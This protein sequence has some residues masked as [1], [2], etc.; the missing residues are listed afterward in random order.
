MATRGMRTSKYSKYARAAYVCAALCFS[1]AAVAGVVA[2]AAA[3]TNPVVSV[4]V[5]DFA[6]TP[7]TLTIVKGTQVRFTNTG[8]S[9]HRVVSDDGTFD[10]HPLQPGHNATFTFDTVGVFHLHCEIHPTMTMSVTVLASQ[11]VAAGAGSGSSS[12]TSESA[13]AATTVTSATTLP[14]TGTGLMTA[15]IA[16]FGL[17]LILLGMVCLAVGRTRFA[18]IPAVAARP[19]MASLARVM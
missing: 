13:T 9:L 14:R 15:L 11:P 2:A 19:A 1:L 16:V 8:E 17:A 7:N 4:S 6:F 5:H 10:S 12:G 18:T 3:A